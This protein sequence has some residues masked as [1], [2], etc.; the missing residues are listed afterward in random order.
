MRSKARLDFS[1][2]LKLLFLYFVGS[3][4]NCLLMA[5]SLSGS[6]LQSNEKNNKSLC[7]ETQKEDQLR[8][9]NSL[10]LLI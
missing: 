7:F 8:S 3:D 4:G 1:W 10:V 6:H 5:Y 9:V 2:V